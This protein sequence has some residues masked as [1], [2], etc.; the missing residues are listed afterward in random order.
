MLSERRCLVQH[1][2]KGYGGYATVGLEL[3]LSVL[4]GLGVGHW[5]DKK[6]GTGFLTWVGLG[7]GIAAGYRTL[8]QA[9]RRANAEARRI[10]E[11]ERETR[12]QFD[13]DRS[14]KR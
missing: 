14:N 5:L 6:L 8:W 9:L 13:E 11:R 7:F 3:A 10:E 2:W 4:F 1:Y 12:K